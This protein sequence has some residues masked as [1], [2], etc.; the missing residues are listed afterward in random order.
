MSAP[1]GRWP[2]LQTATGATWYPNAPTAEDVR[3]ED[4]AAAISK[5]CRFGGH[6]LDFYSVGQHSVL[7]ARLVRAWGLPP[8]VVLQ[9]LVHDA[10]E[11]YP[12][13]DLVSPVK[14]LPGMRGAVELEHAAARV[15]RAHFGVS[16]DLHPVVVDA[17]MVMLATERRDIMATSDVDWGTLPLP[18]LD[19]IEPWDWRRARQ[20]WLDELDYLRGAS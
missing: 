4:V 18:T 3:D 1:A 12:P 19:R 17:D 6:C 10:H 15:V 16:F 13:G 5:L 9:A 11:A 2:W 7:C 8:G 20:E 14:R